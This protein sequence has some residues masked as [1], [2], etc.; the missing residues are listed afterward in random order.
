[1][2]V[3]AFSSTLS[4]IVFYSSFYIPLCYHG[5]RRLSAT[6][7]GSLW[8]SGPKCSFSG[9]LLWV[10]GCHCKVVQKAGAVQTLVLIVCRI[11]HC[12]TELVN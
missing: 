11:A 10:S 5:P 12:P 6:P 8:T 3:T 1:M 2:H 9:W 7:P 4:V